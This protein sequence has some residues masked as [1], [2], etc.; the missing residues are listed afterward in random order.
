[1]LIYCSNNFLL[2]EIGLDRHS[3]ILILAIEEKMKFRQECF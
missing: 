1:M 3:G 2:N